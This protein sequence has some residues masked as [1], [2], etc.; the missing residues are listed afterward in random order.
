[1]AFEIGT[2]VAAPMTIV[3]TRAF[4][5]PSESTSNTSTRFFQSAA[6]ESHEAMQREVDSF[7]LSVV[8]NIYR[9]P[10]LLNQ[11]AT[12][13]GRK[14]MFRHSRPR[15]EWSPR[16]PKTNSRSA[17]SMSVDQLLLNLGKSTLTITS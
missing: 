5:Q 3:V 4:P 12:L 15:S 8:S 2:E 9:V 6:A 1:M 17:F 16:R 13:V 10:L 14:A 7:S 11:L